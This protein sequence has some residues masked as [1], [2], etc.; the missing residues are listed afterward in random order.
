VDRGGLLVQF[1]AVLLIGIARADQNPVVLF[2]VSPHEAGTWFAQPLAA[3]KR[4]K[5][6]SLPVLMPPTTNDADDLQRWADAK[7]AFAKSAFPAGARLTLLDG[8]RSSGTLRVTTGAWLHGKMGVAIPRSGPRERLVPR[9][10]TAAR[11]SPRIS[12]EPPP[13]PRTGARSVRQVEQVMMRRAA[14][15]VF[16]KNGIPIQFI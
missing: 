14:E 7:E 6:E 15:A 11:Y 1:L 13:R 12:G 16:A 4:G 2:A 5:V 3:L 10:P 9:W 8:G